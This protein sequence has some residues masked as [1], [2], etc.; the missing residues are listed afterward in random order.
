M[1]SRYVPHSSE[2]GK[3]MGDGGGG[4]GVRRSADGRSSENFGFE[5]ERAT[6]KS[7]DSVSGE[8]G[9]SWLGEF[10]ERYEGDGMFGGGLLGS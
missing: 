5:S 6:A 2:A 9:E 4:G 3:P 1:P 10:C 7:W 8:R